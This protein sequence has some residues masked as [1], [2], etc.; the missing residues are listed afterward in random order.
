MIEQY[1]ITTPKFNR[2]VEN[3]KLSK[4]QE[5]RI[6]RTIHREFLIKIS[7]A[8]EVDEVTIYRLAKE[9]KNIES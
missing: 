7:K 2:L 1:Y 4:L 6:I 3:L 9:L 5:K 8:S